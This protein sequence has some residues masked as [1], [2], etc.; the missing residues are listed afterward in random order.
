MSIWSK[1]KNKLKVNR[2]FI[3]GILKV[4]GRAVGLNSFTFIEDE[5]Y[6]YHKSVEKF[7]LLKD[8]EVT[9]LWKKNG[10][11]KEDTV[12]CRAGFTW[13]GADIPDSLQGLLG[14][15]FDPEFALASCIHDQ[16]VKM[17]LNHYAESR[18]FYEVLKTRAGRFNIPK[19]KEKAMYV[20]VWMW[21]VYSS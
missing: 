21:S 5:H 13:N 20:A 14:G 19:W 16:A 11:V 4:D 15:R 18:I 7:Q 1:I 12:W 6:V 10:K 9:F 3:V 8:V 17:K 2:K